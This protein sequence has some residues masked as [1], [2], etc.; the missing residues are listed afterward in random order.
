[1][2]RAARLDLHPFDLRELDQRERLAGLFGARLPSDWPNPDFA[3]MARELCRAAEVT[4][5][6]PPLTWAIV[7]RFTATVVGE[8][9]LKGDVDPAGAVEVGYSIREHAR[10]RGYMTEAL[11]VVVDALF[12]SGVRR[13]RA[14]TDPLNLASQR[15]LERVGFVRDGVGVDVIRWVWSGCR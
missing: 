14:E 1:M 12:A 10:G 7:E 6:D 11:D 4:D 5:A 13:V 15:V 2:I 9:G 3:E 8:I